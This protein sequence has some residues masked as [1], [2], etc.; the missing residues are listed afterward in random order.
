MEKKLIEPKAVSTTRLV[1]SEDLNHHGTLFAGRTAEWFVESGFIAA[2]KLVGPTG[3]V[4][5]QIHGL[6]FSQPAKPGEILTFSS[7]V[8]YTGRSSM[9]SYIDVVKEN[10]TEPFVSGF[11]TFIYVDELTR[12]MAH[13]IEITPVTDGDKAL[14]EKAKALKK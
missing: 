13:N 4:C 5:L 9:V 8:V 14:Y 7:K 6:Y 1:K 11:I 2:A 10:Q 3:V 12:P